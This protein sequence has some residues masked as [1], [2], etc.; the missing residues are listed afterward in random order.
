MIRVSA[1]SRIRTVGVIAASGL[2]LAACV[3]PV[4]GPRGVY[5]EPIGWA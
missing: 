5:A 3:S 1:F 4:A 2:A